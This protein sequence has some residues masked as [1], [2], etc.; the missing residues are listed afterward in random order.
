MPLA[1]LAKV[2][3]T[4]MLAAACVS[5]LRSRR[6]PNRIV[7]ALALG[8]LVHAFATTTP[9]AALEHALG[10]GALGL[11]LWLPFWL[12]RMLGAGDVKL[13]AASG[14]WLGVAGTLEASLLG[15]AGGGVLAVWALTRHGG[16]RA[17]AERFGAWMLVSHAT[18]RL[19]PE[20]TPHERRIPYG[21]A[22]A[23]GAAMAL[24]VPGLIW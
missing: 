21:L 15:A 11:A 23:A 2:A 8:G 20:L 13:A 9:L 14:V 24:W 3:F 22:I 5:D 19:G 18:R 17:G 10:G 16:L 1:L 4:L 12:A 6:I 7:V